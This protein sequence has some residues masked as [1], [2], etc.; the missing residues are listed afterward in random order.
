MSDWKS[1]LDKFFE[2]AKQ[3]ATTE[4]IRR[5]E[6]ATEVQIYLQHEI[7]PAFEELRSELEKHGREVS[8]HVG[9]DSGSIIVSFQGK[10]EFHFTIKSNGSR[11]W[12][13]TR[14]REKTNGQIYRAEGIFHGDSSKSDIYH[15]KKNDIIKHFLEDYKQTISR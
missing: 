4:S 3:K 8:V 14:F 5:Q 10:Q 1:D 9:Q 12:P 11:V 2:T 7:L 6:T 15:V 13:E